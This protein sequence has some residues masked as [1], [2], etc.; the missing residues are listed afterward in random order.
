[1]FF[2][3]GDLLSF[4]RYKIQKNV[5]SLKPL[6]LNIRD[7][8]MMLR[9]FKYF[10]C[11]AAFFFC[12]AWSMNLP[13]EKDVQP[14]LQTPKK[15]LGLEITEPEE[16]VP[17][18]II[19]VEISALNLLVWGVDYYLLDKGYA[20]TGP[21]YWKRNF[22]EGWK[23]DH[24]HWAVN[25]YGH[26]YHG[27]RYY[28]AARMGGYGFYGSLLWAAFGSASWEMFAETEY[29]SLNDLITTSMGGAVFGEVFFRFSQMLYG[30]GNESLW[31]RMASLG[32]EPVG[33]I[34]RKIYGNR[35]A[36]IENQPLELDVFLGSGLRL[37]NDFRF[38]GKNTG[39]LDEYWDD[40]HYMFGIN[41]EYG[42]PYTEIKRPFDYFTVISAFAFGDDGSLAHLDITGKLNNIGVR[43]NG[44]WIDFATYLDYDTFYGDFATVGTVSLGGGLD[45]SFWLFSNLRFRMSNQLYWIVLGTT[46]MGYDDILKEKYPE[47]DPDMDSYQ[48]NTGVKYGLYLELGIWKNVRFC[49]RMN[50]EALHTMPNSLPHYGAYGWDLLLFNYTWVD[51]YMTRRVSLGTRLDTYMKFAA[52]H[53]ELFEPM[54]RRMFALTLYVNVRIL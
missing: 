52:Y 38:D 3:I 33:Y 4:Y 35:Y 43:G 11:V 6:Y 28:A 19:A 51:V 13:V 48:Y 29:P 54:S 2:F 27:S 18:S 21:D 23:W 12:K 20:H 45:I 30:N 26:P 1:M 17:A 22:R 25:F 9:M 34:Q 41:A 24:N 40:T 53:S 5:F 32:V 31:R 36:Q 50:L 10:F 16:R 15:I 46:D 37:G 8:S 39:E 47:Y 7:V 44:R 49:N 14:L 42:R